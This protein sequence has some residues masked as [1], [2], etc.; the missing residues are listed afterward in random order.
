[1]KEVFLLRV[2]KHHV[3]GTFG[4]AKYNG[5]PFMVTLEDP[6]RDNA[7]GKSCIP[8]GTYKVTL[9]SRS[10]EYGFQPSHKY[11]DIYTVNNVPGRTYILIHKG[12]V[13]QDTEGC[14]LTGEE[15]GYLNNQPAIRASGNAFNEFM[16]LMGGEDFLLHIEDHTNDS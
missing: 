8:E 4:V 1:M 14:I 12:N 13:H 9:C 11:G 7:P 3:Y 5:I 15:F 2:A 6:D 10:A 16:A